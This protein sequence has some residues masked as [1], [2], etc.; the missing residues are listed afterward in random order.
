MLAAQRPD[1]DDP[2]RR[3]TQPPAHFAGCSD[4]SHLVGL[5]VIVHVEDRI[6][7]RALFSLRA[8]TPKRLLRKEPPNFSLAFL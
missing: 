1:V 4:L 6:L 5:P 3:A 7:Y 8:V 2:N